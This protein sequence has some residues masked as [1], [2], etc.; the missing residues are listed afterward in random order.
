MAVGVAEKD[1]KLN[2]HGRNYREASPPCYLASPTKVISLVLAR[3]KSLA[4]S[5][6]Y[7][8]TAMRAMDLALT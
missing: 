2:T 1:S 7:A 6:R 5:G 3:Q 8:L 4:T